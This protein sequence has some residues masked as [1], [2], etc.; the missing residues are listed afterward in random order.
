MTGVQTCALPIY[1]NSA[2]P[3][4]KEQ[5]EAAMVAYREGATDYVG[6]IQ[7]MKD[8]TQTELDYWNAYAACLNARFNLLYYYN[9]P[10]N[11]TNENE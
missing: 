8:A 6:F 2:L 1:Q 10:P 5:K 4:A 7:N 3:V 9:Y 11:K